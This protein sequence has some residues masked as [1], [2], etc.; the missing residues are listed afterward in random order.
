MKRSSISQAELTRLAKI[1]RAEGICIE[2]T[3]GDTNIKLYPMSEKDAE[4]AML[5]RELDEFDKRQGYKPKP[6]GDL[7]ADKAFESLVASAIS[8]KAKRSARRKRS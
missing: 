8:E 5:D 1:S 6:T 4:I 2:I 7:I 3:R